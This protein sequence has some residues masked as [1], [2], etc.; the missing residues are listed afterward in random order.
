MCAIR[1]KFCQLAEIDKVSEST[2]NTAFLWQKCGLSD[3]ENYSI[4][5]I[6]TYQKQVYL[7]K[8]FDQ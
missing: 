2:I 3:R 8:H 1:Q 6:F 4:G 5:K 7:Q